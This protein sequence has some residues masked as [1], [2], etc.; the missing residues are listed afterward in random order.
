MKRLLLVLGGAYL[1]AAIG[2]RVAEQLGAATCDCDGDCWSGGRV[3]AS[4]AGCS[5]AGTAALTPRSRR[6]TW[7]ARTAEVAGRQ[8]VGGT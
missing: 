8:Q 3:S 1:A 4:S 7:T 6:P 5:H 2:S